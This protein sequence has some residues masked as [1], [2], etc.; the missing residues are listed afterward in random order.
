MGAFSSRSDNNLE[1]ERLI[2]SFCRISRDEL[3]DLLQRDMPPAVLAIQF[4]VTTSLIRSW[5][6]RNAVAFDDGELL[7]KVREV[8]LFEGLAGFYEIL[9]EKDLEKGW[10]FFQAVLEITDSA[11][12]DIYSSLETGPMEAVRHVRKRLGPIGDVFDDSRIGPA[13]LKC[14]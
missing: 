9:E 14:S 11:M 3:L 7:K 13:L 6:K 4:A 2:S 12:E 10:S 1:A 5:M 8:W